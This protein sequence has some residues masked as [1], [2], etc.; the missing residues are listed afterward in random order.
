M[1]TNACTGFYK[2]ILPT[3][4]LSLW[5]ITHRVWERG[6]SRRDACDPRP[7]HAFVLASHDANAV[8]TRATPL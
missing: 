7:R 1:S 5:S 6:S 4:E 8:L 3:A 2:A